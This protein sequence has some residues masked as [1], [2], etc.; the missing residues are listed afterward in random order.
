MQKPKYRNPKKS[1]NAPCSYL[2]AHKGLFWGG[3]VVGSLPSV[4][5]TQNNPPPKFELSVH[6]GSSLHEQKSGQM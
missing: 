1:P 2:I 6:L 4:V 5:G 3:I